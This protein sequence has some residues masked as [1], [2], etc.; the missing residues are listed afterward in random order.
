MTTVQPGL[1]TRLRNPS[2]GE[3]DSPTEARQVI[4]AAKG[5]GY[6]GGSSFSQSGELQPRAPHLASHFDLTHAPRL[7]MLDHKGLYDTELQLEVSDGTTD[8]GRVTGSLQ[9][10]E[11]RDAQGQLQASAAPFA[12]TLEG[13]VEIRSASGQPIGGISELR[14]L[15][16]F[17]LL[18]DPSG[19]V[20]GELKVEPE[21]RR[22]SLWIHGD[23]ALQIGWTEDLKGLT[24][25]RNE[26]AGF[27][28][29]LQ[30]LLPA[31][32]T[33]RLKAQA[34][35][36]LRQQLLSPETLGAIVATL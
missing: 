18:V 25:V 35:D 31:V 19:D 11:L 30:I 8:L 33:L 23:E 28:S 4:P 32:L 16:G 12:G 15:D 36:R 7:G 6:P 20:M 14:P 2:W 24:V 17:A 13:A 1:P 26:T 9:G 21:Q 10:L 3:V 34:G 5:V 27:A 29:E 22:A